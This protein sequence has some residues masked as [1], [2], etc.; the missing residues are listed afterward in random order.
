MTVILPSTTR[1]FKQCRSFKLSD[2][3]FCTF[4]CCSMSETCSAH[5]I[6]LITVGVAYKAW[7]CSLLGKFTKLRK[8][9]TS[10]VMSVC[11][12]VCLFVHMEQTGSHWM[13]FHEIW[14][15]SIFREY[16]EENLSL[17][18]DKN[19]GYFTWRP[20][21]IYVSISLNCSLNEKC[22]RRTL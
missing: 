16:F 8:I 5:L 12:S 14:Y 7:S 2:Q 17:K 15:S 21:Y 1:S 19:N 4:L 9:T 20:I 6:L 13:N 18:Y 11:L 10:F 3:N 22:F